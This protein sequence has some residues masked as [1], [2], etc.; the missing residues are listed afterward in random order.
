MKRTF[1]VYLLLLACLNAQAQVARTPRQRRIVAPATTDSCGAAVLTVAA[2]V[3]GAT[4]RR[5][6]GVRAT[7]ACALR[8]AKSRRKTGKVRFIVGLR[9]VL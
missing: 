8:H 1:P 2:F 5:W 3:A 6:R 9:S 4:M 7:C